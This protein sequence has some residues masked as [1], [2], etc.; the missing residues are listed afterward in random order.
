MPIKRIFIQI[1]I[2]IAGL[3]LMGAL[4][5]FVYVAHLSGELPSS[6]QLESLAF[7]NTSLA[8]EVFDRNGKKIGEFASERRYFKS[9][10]SMPKH[11]IQAFLAAEDKDFYEHYG[12]SPLAIAR[13]GTAN[14]LGGGISQGASTITQQLVRLY[15]LTPKRTWSR[16]IKEALLSLAVEKR[17]TK[18]Q[19]LELYLNKIFF[20]NRSYG[21]ESAARN[22]FRKGVE[23]LNLG[24]AA[25]LAGLPKAPSHYA[26]HRFPERASERQAVVLGRMARLG[27]ITQAEAEEWTKKSILVEKFPERF[28]DRA[29]YFLQA[30]RNELGRKFEFDHL[31]SEGLKIY[32]SLDLSLQQQAADALK[33]GVER[34]SRR[35]KRLKANRGSIQGAMIALDPK[36][37]G[38]LAMQGGDDFSASEFNR[39]E[40]ANRRLGGVY[41]PLYAALALERGYSLASPTKVAA[42]GAASNKRRRG[43]SIY[44]AI[45]QGDIYEGARLYANL[46]AGTVKE[47][48]EK[49][50]LNFKRDDL[51]LSIGYGEATPLDLAAAYSVIGNGGVY[52]EPHLITGI[53]DRDGAKLYQH[54]GMGRQVLEQES[55]YI[56][57]YAMQ[58][59]VR[60]GKG[61]DLAGISEQFGA[62]GGV[63]DEF[64]NS[65]IV[66]ATPNILTT[67]WMGAERGRT[68]LAT[69]EDDAL[70]VSATV[71]A[72]F[73]TKIDRPWLANEPM[74]APE[75]VSFGR[76]PKSY[77]ISQSVPFKIG[78]EP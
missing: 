1:I 4:G 61:Q 58:D 55:A 75:R 40:M 48:T 52:R 31:P 51:L 44:E 66:G 78:T 76:L 6:K 35:A 11:L 68:R 36:T 24:E 8:T 22:Y 38:V 71:L 25:L 46:G 26:P 19:I 12:I 37:G 41:L 69:E 5:L 54:R 42:M 62:F 3:G 10:E 72:D 28:T 56:M 32:T 59:Y 49:I 53:T 13:A 17:L 23:N 64:H 33:R 14:V 57:S 9:I 50:G 63:S 20:G 73:A 77:K 2:A 30:V 21:V 74:A 39:V 29:P 70:Q 27:M 15:F 67:V 16:K 60:Y 65:W 43:M 34:T 45:I 7:E 47:F 18:D